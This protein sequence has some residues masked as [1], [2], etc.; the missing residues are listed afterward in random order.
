MPIMKSIC[1]EPTTTRSATVCQNP[2]RR[3]EPCM[4]W[5]TRGRA[6]RRASTVIC[7]YRDELLFPIAFERFFANVKPRKNCWSLET[8]PVY[9]RLSGLDV[10]DATMCSSEEVP[11]DWIPGRGIGRQWQRSEWSSIGLPTS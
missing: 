7:T 4:P 2:R 5:T 8:L 6:T 10:R 9:R 1:A 11:C 3:R